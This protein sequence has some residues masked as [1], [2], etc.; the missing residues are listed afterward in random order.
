MIS[1]YRDIWP[2]RSHILAPLTT[3]TSEKVEWKWTAEHQSAFD[4]M[5][6]VIAQETLLAYPKFD[7]ILD[8]HMDA[9]LY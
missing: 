9:S 6:R 2:Q 3:L 7:K 1:Y 4:E 8:I 5:K